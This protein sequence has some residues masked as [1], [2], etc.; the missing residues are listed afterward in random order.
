MGADVATLE[1]E[2]V[3][4]KVAIAIMEVADH[5]GNVLVKTD[6]ATR[7]V[8]QVAGE[9]VKA[10]EELSVDDGLDFN[11]AD[12]LSDDALGEFTED[13]QL[14]LDDVNALVLADD[15]LLLDFNDL[16]VEAAEVVDTIEVIEVGKRVKPA[17]VVEGDGGEAQ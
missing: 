17:P 16:V 6:G 3:E 2:V 7:L 9:V 10:G 1:A 13:S 4:D 8:E 12:G 11:L 15:L 5:V 14:L